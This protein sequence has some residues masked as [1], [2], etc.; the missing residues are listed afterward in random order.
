MGKDG[1]GEAYGSEVETS[2]FFLPFGL[3]KLRDNPARLCCCAKRRFV[4]EIRGDPRYT[5]RTCSIEE[6]LYDDIS[7]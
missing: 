4:I 7:S 2:G 1:C 6:S 3:A 5:H